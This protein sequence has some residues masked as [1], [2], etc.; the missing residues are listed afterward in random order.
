MHRILAFGLEQVAA[1]AIKSYKKLSPW[2][3]L[4]FIILR[5]LWMRLNLKMQE[6]SLHL[7]L[8]ILKLSVATRLCLQSG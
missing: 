1:P 4:T 8:Q 3:T 7:I 5:L 2:T 6:G